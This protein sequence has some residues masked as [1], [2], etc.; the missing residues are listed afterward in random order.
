MVI[1]LDYRVIGTVGSRVVLYC[2]FLGLVREKDFEEG[3][4]IA[5]ELEQN[6][7]GWQGLETQGPVAIPEA[8]LL[9]FIERHQEG[10]LTPPNG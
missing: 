4:V 1:L 6:P 5:V 9:E 7:D 3:Y 8:C 10:C 2:H